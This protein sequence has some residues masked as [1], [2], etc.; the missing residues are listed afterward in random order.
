MLWQWANVNGSVTA[1]GGATGVA[2]VGVA[3]QTSGAAV[4]VDGNVT[5]DGTVP[6]GYDT[7]DLEICGVVA[8]G[9]GSTVQIGGAVT[10]SGDYRT[11]ASAMEGGTV[12]VDGNVSA[13]ATGAQADKGTAVTN[14]VTI[15]GEI[16]TTGAYVKIGGVSKTAADGAAGTSADAGYTVFTVTNA[17]ST[18]TVR[19]SASGAPAITSANHTSIPAKGSIFH[20][21]ATGT[22]PLTYSL[23]GA[24]DGVSINSSTGLITMNAAYHRRVPIRPLP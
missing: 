3:A 15:K 4:T 21:T 14:L 1:D 23:T 24:P 10:I 22:A 13:N 20:V 5:V 7:T 12:T 8:A 19:V 18:H 9:A 6:G 17:G 11:G 2:F 16:Q